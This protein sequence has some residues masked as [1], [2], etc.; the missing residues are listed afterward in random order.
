MSDYLYKS[1]K[2]SKKNYNEFRESLTNHTDLFKEIRKINIASIAE[3]LDLDLE[4]P[5]IEVSEVKKNKLIERVHPSLIP[6]HSYLANIDGVVKLM[7][8][9]MEDNK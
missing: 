1:N 4:N 2:E 8:I 3:I 6:I 7:R 9:P 5:Y